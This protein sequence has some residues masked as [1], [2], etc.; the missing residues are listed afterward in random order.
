[1]TEDN[2]RISSAIENE[3]LVSEKERVPRQ[4]ANSKFQ[5]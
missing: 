1:L 5:I 4:Q 3:D 2:I